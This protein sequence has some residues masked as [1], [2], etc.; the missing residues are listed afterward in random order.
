M[1]KLMGLLY[2]FLIIN[3]LINA[4]AKVDGHILCLLGMLKVFVID[5]QFLNFT[6]L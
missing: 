3:W 6:F 4:I 1:S 5:F 2:G